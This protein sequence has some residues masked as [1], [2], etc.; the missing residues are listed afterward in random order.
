LARIWGERT[1][2]HCWW[3]F[4]LVL[5]LWKAVWQLLNELKIKLA[6]DT[7]T[8]LLGVYL[9]KNVSEGTIKTLAHPCLFSHKE[10]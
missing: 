7:A 4:K 2:I 5:L 1:L 9:E 8:P 3:E 10:E 6:Y